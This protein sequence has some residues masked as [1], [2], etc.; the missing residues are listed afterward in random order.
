MALFGETAPP[1]GSL[2]AATEVSGDLQQVGSFRDWLL[3]AFSDLDTRVQVLDRRLQQAASSCEA[4]AHQTSLE[5]ISLLKDSQDRMP[6]VHEITVGLS[7]RTQA[8]SLS[9]QS[10]TTLDAPRMLRPVQ[11]G[12][13]N[14]RDQF[15]ES[16][17]HIA[18]LSK[19]LTSKVD[20]KT[21]VMRKLNAAWTAAAAGGPTLT[22]LADQIVAT[23]NEIEG[24]GDRLSQKMDEDFRARDDDFEKA[25]SEAEAVILEL[26]QQANDQLSQS[27]ATLRR[28]TNQKI[29]IQRSIDEI[30]G[31]IQARVEPRLERLKHNIRVGE[32]KS[33]QK[34]E[35]IQSRLSTDF[36]LVT[37]EIACA[38]KRSMLDDIEYE[39]ELCEVESLLTEIE[40]IKDKLENF[41]GRP[42]DLDIEP[43]EEEQFNEPVSEE[44]LLHA[45]ANDQPS[46]PGSRTREEEEEEE[47]IPSVQPS[48]PRTP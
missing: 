24:H 22:K 31:Q 25:L 35:E 12:F 6:A 5:L 34:L 26:D 39:R 33:S 41:D 18:T 19:L 45:L 9:A 2:L 46:A 36:D 17:K 47:N 38:K 21:S 28:I 10:A 11:D 4:S 14:L 44:F 7:R 13:F 3:K 16:L 40:F 1:A 23:S 8:L 30:A 48:D 43:E 29:D 42:F 32:S 20:A 15:D 27:N 37:D